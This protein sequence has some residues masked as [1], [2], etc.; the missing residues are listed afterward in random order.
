MLSWELKFIQFL[1]S[2][3]QIQ[4]NLFKDT[5]EQGTVAKGIW[6]LELK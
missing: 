4:T 5:V 6:T 1:K 2:T 3:A